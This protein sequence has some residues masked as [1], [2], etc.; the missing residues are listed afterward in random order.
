MK[1]RIVLL[2]LILIC[3]T[4]L[5][6]AQESQTQE[7]RKENS[8]PK[9]FVTHHKVQIENQSVSYSAVSGEIILK[10]EDGAPKASVFTISYLKDGTRDLSTRPITFFFNGGPGSSAVWLHLGAFGPKRLNLSSD[11]V[12]PGAPPYQLIDNTHTLLPYSDLVFVDPIGTGFSKALGK[13]KDKDYWGVDEDSKSLAEFIRAYISKNKRWNSPK[14]LAG[15]S[16]GTIRVSAL[17]RDLQLKLLDSVT[18]N[19]VILISTAVDV[20][21]FLDA[22]PGNELPYITNLPTYAATAYFHNVL[23]QRPDNLEKFLDDARAFASTE[24]LEALFMGDSLPEDRAREII[25]KLHF[26]TGLKKDFLQRSHFRVETSRFLKELLRDRG[27][28]LA[29]H[30][31]R[32][33]GKDED[34]AGETVALDPFLFGIAGPFVSAMNNYLSTDLG[35]KIEEPYKTFSIEAAQ[36]WKRAGDSNGVF[37]GFLHNGSN[38][39]A[40]A[41]TNKDFRL[42]VASGL[43]DLTTTFYG[44]EYIFNHTG[45]DKSRITLKNYYGGHMMYLYGPSLEQLVNDI[46]KFISDGAKAEK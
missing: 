27:Q 5:I 23:P 22:G 19:G 21:T 9:E 13:S 29:V 46:G 1:N 33:L 6:A 24:Y 26:F 20:R 25:N 3:F 40:A 30:D 45:I 36:S 7:T 28:T 34:D 4:Q 38:L 16:Y 31:T 17:V 42:F 37:D 43:H 11:P 15:E 18:L 12:N 14:F 41:S 35:V 44:S 39:S 2:A 8:G 32:F 10:D